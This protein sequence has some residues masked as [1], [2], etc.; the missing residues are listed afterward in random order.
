MLR[1][2]L[3]FLSKEDLLK[4]GLDEIGEMLRVSEE[5]FREVVGR[6]LEGAPVTFDVHQRDKI[7]NKKEK[8]IRRMVLEHLSVSPKQDIV[9]SLVLTTV[10]SYIERIGDYTKNIVELA[11]HHPAKLQ[12]GPF[13]EGVR[14]IETT[15]KTMFELLIQSFPENDESK[16][17]EV[18]SE[19]WWI[20]RRGDEI[21]NTLIESEERYRDYRTAYRGPAE[22]EG[23]DLILESIREMRAEKDLRIGEYYE[24]TDHTDSA[25][26]YYRGVRRDFP[27]TLASAKAAERLS[28][29]GAPIQPEG[30]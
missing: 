2:L 20:A 12:C 15:V 19:H 22:R 5:M 26:F 30:S 18:M 10:V 23:V 21:M 6:L 1:E 14:K 7:L 17:R 3:A 25:V 9:A 29:L 28:L 16:A 13:E 4:Q 24:R 27:N 8:E 11:L